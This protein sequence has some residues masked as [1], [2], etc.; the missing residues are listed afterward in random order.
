MTKRDFRHIRGVSAAALADSDQIL[1]TMR[2][3]I[4]E[5]LFEG[6]PPTFSRDFRAYCR[7]EADRDDIDDC[8]MIAAAIAGTLVGKMVAELVAERVRE[9]EEEEG[10]DRTNG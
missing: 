7:R 6:A 4:R 2:Q 8:R 1:E 3:A 9:V 10:H 5:E